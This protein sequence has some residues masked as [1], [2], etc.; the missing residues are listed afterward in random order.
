MPPGGGPIPGG[1]P[2]RPGPIGPMPG[3]IPP[4]PGPFASWALFRAAWTASITPCNIA[5]TCSAAASETKLQAIVTSTGFVGPPEP[6]MPGI[7]GIMPGI[8]PGPIP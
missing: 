3:G 5:C 4:G 6:P 2:P 7:P 8:M 1:G